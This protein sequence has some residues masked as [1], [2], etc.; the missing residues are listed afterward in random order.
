VLTV[1]LT[2]VVTDSVTSL[3]HNALHAVTAPRQAT[4]MQ[5]PTDV[6]YWYPASGRLPAQAPPAYDPKSWIAHCGVWKKWLDDHH[7]APLTNQVEI[8][9]TAPADAPLTVTAVDVHVFARQRMNGKLISC[10]YGAGGEAGTSIHPNLDSP[11]GPIPMDTDG[12]G[13]TDAQLPGGRFLV[14]PGEFEWLTI[15]AKATAGYVYE[16]GLVFH[17]VVNGRQRT[18]MQGTPAQP[19]RLAFGDR[20]I[21]TARLPSY[22]W[23]LNS[24]RWL[25]TARYLKQRNTER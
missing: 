4:R 24:H 22:D 12:D 25:P 5:E 2:G 15:A 3:G 23:D 20:G 14:N 8:G 1:V 16:I 9:V 17:V 21:Y 11:A 7:A 19:I 18:E 6:A 10:T 13:K